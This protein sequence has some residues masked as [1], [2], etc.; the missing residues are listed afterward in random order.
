MPAAADLLW[1]LNNE[2]RRRISQAS[3]C[4]NLLEQ[5]VMLQEADDQLR[6][7]AAL[8]Y[9]ADQ[10][11]LMEE[12]ARRWRHRYYYET[13]ET[14]R[15]VQADDAVH[16]ALDRFS[17]MRADHERRMDDLIRLFDHVQRPSPDITAVPTGDLWVMT[18]Y[19]L[20]DLRGFENYMQS[21]SQI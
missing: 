17:R 12:E 8:R 21:V 3:T 18:T 11:E 4:L 5:L 10:I 19:A 20:D 15:M 7:L 13:L 14:R 2:Y 1:R 16:H 6:T 9:A